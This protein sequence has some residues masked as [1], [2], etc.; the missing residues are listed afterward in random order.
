MTVLFKGRSS[1]GKLDKFCR[2]NEI[3]RLIKIQTYNCQGKFDRVKPV[4]N[5]YICYIFYKIVAL[6]LPAQKYF[7]IIQVKYK[8][9][10]I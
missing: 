5:S 1:Q 6:N 10:V 7:T 4:N 2:T 9:P 8:Y 3:L